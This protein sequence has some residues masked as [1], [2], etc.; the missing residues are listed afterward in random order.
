[1]GS[2]AVRLVTAMGATAI[3]GV[4]S[5]GKRER[6]LALGAAAAVSFSSPGWADQIREAT[7]GRGADVVLQ[8]TGGDIGRESLRALAPLGRLVL[9]GAD[10]V[11]HPEPLGADQARALIAQGQSFSGFGLMRLPA[12]VRSRAFAELVDRVADGALPLEIVRYP[13][14]AVRQAHT[15]VSGRKTIGKVVLEPR[16]S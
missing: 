7:G 9:F 14:D 16:A 12:D 1:V 6:A 8:S 13:F 11:V 3:A 2:V 10:N 15:D 5:D 4:G